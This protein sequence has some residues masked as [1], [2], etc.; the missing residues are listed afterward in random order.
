MAVGVT[1][2]LFQGVTATNRFC[3]TNKFRVQIVHYFTWKQLEE[4]P[5]ILN[6]YL[7]PSTI[8]SMD[9]SNTYLQLFHVVMFAD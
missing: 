1:S 7:I 5:Y 8:T 9:R 4:K 3:Q 2:Q 6:F